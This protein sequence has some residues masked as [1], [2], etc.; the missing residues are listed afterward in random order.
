MTE[1][2]DV[3]THVDPSADVLQYYASPELRER[4]DELSRYII[5]QY[6][7]EPGKRRVFRMRPIAYRRRPGSHLEEAGQ[8]AARPAFGVGGVAQPKV[9]GSGRI[10]VADVSD[11]NAE[12]RLKDMDAEGV[13]Q[14]LIIPG[15]WAAACTAIDR[16]LALLLYEAYHRYMADYCSADSS[17]LRGVMLIPG[18]DPATAAEW[19]RRYG[20][21][22]WCGAAQIMLP[23][24]LPVD[25]PDL[26]PIWEALNELDLALLV[27]PFTYEPPYF[28]GYR[29]IWD[30][31]VVARTAALPW[32]AQRLLAYLI[33]GGHFDRWPNLRA[34]F[35][36][37]S[38]GW[39]P[40]WLKRL[41][42]N[43]HY[44]S[45]AVDLPEMSP[46]DYVRGGRVFCGIE[47]YEGADTA[48][49]LIDLAGSDFLLYS[50]DYPHS[51]CQ[52]PDSPSVVRSWE[53]EIGADALEK[54]LE[55]NPRRYLRR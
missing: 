3:D 51:E 21:E 45:H 38:A 37:T 33:L 39:L 14:H 2:I 11:R 9:Q 46:L 44:L 28:P 32:N 47:L 19:I 53:P 25:D 34:G 54:M 35:L 43:M 20:T 17:R 23:E 36:E 48:K 6:P 31:I 52:W 13:S 24:G 26:T 5:E 22:I 4:W 30:N 7:D 50:S 1:I 8:T 29:D 55:A 10:A 41:D 27:H 12:L 40:W 42:M 16:D 15:V 49:S 18:Q